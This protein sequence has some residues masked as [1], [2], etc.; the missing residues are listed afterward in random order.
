MTLKDWADGY[1]AGNNMMMKAIQTATY[2]EQERII[3]LLEDSRELRG[4]IYFWEEFGENDTEGRDRKER[5]IA[6]IKGE[7]QTEETTTCYSCQQEPK[8]CNCNNTED[9]R[10]GN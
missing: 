4:H 2:L 6:L 3:K 8:H 5:A 10:T 1:D 7:N 9:E